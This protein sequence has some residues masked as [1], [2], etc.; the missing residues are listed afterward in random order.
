MGCIWVRSKAVAAR[1]RVTLKVGNLWELLWNIEPQKPWKRVAV[2]QFQNWS[3]QSCYRRDWLTW[4]GL[5]PELGGSFFRKGE[6]ERLGDWL[7]RRVEKNVRCASTERNPAA[8][9]LAGTVT[10][11]LI[12]WVFFRK[13]GACEKCVCSGEFWPCCSLAAAQ[14]NLGGFLVNI[15][16][17][18]ICPQWL[19]HFWC[20]TLRLMTLHSG[21]L[22]PLWK[23]VWIAQ[24]MVTVWMDSERPL[25]QPQTPLHG[26]F[27]LQPI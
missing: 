3:E 18:A 20:L 27:S 17:E 7:S 2:W 19:P 14:K 24:A 11:T 10:S 16:S 23:L 4:E 22:V 9:N 13:T 15:V 8:A 12:R 1:Q 25:K 5:N 6:G 26:G 21:G